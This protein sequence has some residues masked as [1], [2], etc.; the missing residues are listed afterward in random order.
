MRTEKT[1]KKPREF[2]GYIIVH[3][4]T[5]GAHKRV[6][7]GTG[8]HRGYAPDGRGMY[9]GHYDDVTILPGRGL[10]TICPCGA[11]LSVEHGTSVYGRYAEQVV[12]SS[13]CTG[14]SGPSCDCSCGGRN[15]GGR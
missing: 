7:V 14:A 11:S 13:K 8:F 2:T 6:F 5:C 15:H 1:V 9:D 12:C 10:V 4:R 3:H